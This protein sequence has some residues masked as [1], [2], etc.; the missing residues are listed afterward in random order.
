VAAVVFVA[1]AVVVWHGRGPIG[2]DD[3]LGGAAFGPRPHMLRL[4]HLTSLG[5]PLFV[6]PA[7]VVVA[8]V[9]AVR[10]DAVA[11]ALCA[12]GPALAGLCVLVA[13]P[14][15]DRLRGSAD[16]YPSGHATLAAALATTLVLVAY[17]LGGVRAAAIV[18]VPATLLAGGVAVAIVRLG[19]HYPSDAI[20]GAALG[21]GVVCGTYAALAYGLGKIGRTS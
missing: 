21:V 11:V 18:A 7:L 5:A 3:L 16:S 13:K 14:T 10:R 6:V 2:I 12:I 1:L 4:H 8:V 15:V 19:W 9:A 17:R 20:G